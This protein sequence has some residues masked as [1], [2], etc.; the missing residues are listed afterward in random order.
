M[1][2][3]ILLFMMLMTFSS[4]WAQIEVSLPDGSKS[5]VFD[6]EDGVIKI[7]NYKFCGICAGNKYCTYCF[8]R[9][10]KTIGGVWYSCSFCNGRGFCGNCGGNGRK[11][12]QWFYNSQKGTLIFYDPVT[13]YSSM[14]NVDAPAP[15][16]RNNYTNSGERI[17]NQCNGSRRQRIPIPCPTEV[18]KYCEVCD[19]IMTMASYHIHQVCSV[20]HGRGTVK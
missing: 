11:E 5:Y 15:S 7:V 20:C 12:T 2:K 13:G 3:F 18:Y 6:E 1:K 9:C 4:S 8:G 16:T 17:C 10:G 19:Q 14:S